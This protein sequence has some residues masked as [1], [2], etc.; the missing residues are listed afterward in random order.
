MEQTSDDTQKTCDIFEAHS[1]AKLLVDMRN[2]FQSCV[3]AIDA[4]LNFIGKAMLCEWDPT[5]I[6]WIQTEGPRGLY[7]KTHSQDNED[8]KAMLQDLKAHSGKLTRENHF[9]WL[10]HDQT[11]IGRKKRQ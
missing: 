2:G 4:H 10:F 5:N 6:K 9:Y 3:E 7:E 8:F 1:S 11:T